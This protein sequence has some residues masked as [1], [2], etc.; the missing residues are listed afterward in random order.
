MTRTCATTTRPD[1][2]DPV[3][4][5]R[6]PADPVHLGPLRGVAT[7]LAGQCNMDLDRLAD[8]RLAVDETCSTLLRI[9][10]PGTDIVCRFRLSPDSFR[11]AAAVSAPPEEADAPVERKFGWHVLRTLTDELEITRGPGAGPDRTA[12]TIAFT[13]F[14]G[15]AV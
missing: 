11:L 1:E 15:D 5:L 3:L 10:L 2:L 6:A 13:M 12:V 7:A 4:E 8:L 9:A 14:G